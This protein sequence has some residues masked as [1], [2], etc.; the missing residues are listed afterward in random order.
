MTTQM[1]ILVA[2]DFSESAALALAQ[3]AKLAGT[4][5]ARLHLC[6][7]VPATGVD[8]PVSLGNEVPAEFPEAL[9]ARR[10]LEGLRA[11]LAPGLDVELHLRIGDP[12]ETLL[13]LI[14]E[15]KPDLVVVCSHGK[16]LLSRALLGSVSRRLVERSPAP[17]LV[18]PAPGRGVYA[19]EPVPEPELPAVGRPVGDARAVG[20]GT[21]GA[22]DA[23]IAGTAG[24]GVKLR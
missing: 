5:G 17:V 20:G 10:Q 3:G 12:V 11:G 19:P 9:E 7:A 13:G 14:Q 22:A 21:I 6:H 18:V 23:G 2:T 16:G 24:I 1:Q 4:T 15:L 8:A